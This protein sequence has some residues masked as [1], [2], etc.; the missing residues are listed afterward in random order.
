M[1]NPY[2]SPQSGP[3][4]T[5]LD[6]DLADPAVLRLARIGEIAVAWENLRLPYNIMLAVVAL[7]AVLNINAELLANPRAMVAMLLAALA[8]NA[9][10][11]VG[12]LLE[13]YV[14]WFLGPVPWLRG[15]VFVV[16]SMGAIGLTMVVVVMVSWEGQV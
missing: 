13:G 8:A 7:V 16:G 3:R 9:C 10:F 2:T 12:P 6:D 5:P 11:C 4:P 15:V 14:T 1:E